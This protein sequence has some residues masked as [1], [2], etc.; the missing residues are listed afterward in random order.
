MAEVTMRKLDGTRELS[1]RTALPPEPVFD[2][3]SDFTRHP[4]WCRDLVAMDKQEGTAV[5]VGARYE[6]TESMREGSRMKAKTSCEVLTL[7]RPRLIEWSA[8]TAA[9]KGPMAM[10]STWAFIIEPDGSGSHVIQRYSFQPP[11]PSSKVM[12]RGF[13]TFA[14]LFGGLGASPKNVRKH[15]EALATRLDESAATAAV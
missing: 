15:A 14:D 13:S 8:R 7:D 9:S 11:G 1:F 2:Y 12:L 6:T 4:E 10:R 3:L 5:G